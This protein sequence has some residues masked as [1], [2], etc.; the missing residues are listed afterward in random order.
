MA[1]ILDQLLSM[2]NGQGAPALANS[3]QGGPTTNM[4]YT[5][6]MQA[7][8][9][10]MPTSQLVDARA[11]RP[12]AAAQIDPRSAVLPVGGASGSWGAPAAPAA[13][14]PQ[15]GLGSNLLA[16]L[17]QLPQVGDKLAA[18]GAPEQLDEINVTGTPARPVPIPPSRPGDMGG[19]PPASAMPVSLKTNAVA[20]AVSPAPSVAS[21]AAPASS[22]FFD[23]DRGEKVREW[24]HN[25]F[26]GLA[27]G[28]NL[29]E[30]LRNAAIYSAQ[31][32][33]SGNVNQTREAAVRMGMDP[34]TA[35]SLDGKSLASFVISQ[36][37]ARLKGVE[38]TNDIREFNFAK[39]QGF[40]GTFEDWQTKKRGAGDDE[41]GTSLTYGT[42]KDGN[43]IA[44]QASKKGTLKQVDLPDGTK[45]ST[46]VDKIDLGTQWGMVNRKTGEVVGYAPKDV[47]GENRQKAIGTA[48]GGA[49][50]A[51]PGAEIGS[52]QISAQIE[53]LKNDPAL[54]NVVGP[55]DGR[56]PNLTA[57]SQRV[58]S[59]IDRLKGGVFLQAFNAL[60]G[61]G[62]ISEVEGAKAEQAMARLNQ[63]QS[64]GDFKQALDEFND[65]VRVGLAKIKAN[66]GQGGGGAPAA[67]V[68]TSSPRVRVWDPATGTL[69]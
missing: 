59:K 33:Q 36:Q 68:P 24:L 34:A 14:A 42:D 51:L 25:A 57:D 19:Q 46:G 52:D 53:D 18:A 8:F 2:L 38:P 3:Q 9:A 20:S 26:T 30:G 10:G 32:G 65:A 54:P 43:T 45:L 40:E 5:P 69:R 11:D 62:A 67:S 66:A 23:S 48:Q 29:P 7:A 61:G 35:K 28:R 6:A 47:V 15:S 37:Q 58:Q 55:I 44:F 50:A 22:S 27:T 64:E 39:Q 63:A 16:S 41:F 56:T 31:A 1:N 17:G 12:G 13:P 21:P 4:P 60:K 49:A